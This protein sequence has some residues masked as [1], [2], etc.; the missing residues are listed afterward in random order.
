[1]ERIL[2]ER[3]KVLKA[4]VKD[5]IKKIKT[6]LL[7][8]QL[9][10][11]YK[12]SDEFLNEFVLKFRNDKRIVKNTI[13][14]IIEN[15]D[16][17]IDYLIEKEKL[18][19]NVFGISLNLLNLALEENGQKIYSNSKDFIE[20]IE[21]ILETEKINEEFS[22]KN[23]FEIVSKKGIDIYFFKNKTGRYNKAKNPSEFENY[24][25]NFLIEKITD[26]E[27]RR[28]KSDFLEVIRYFSKMVSDYYTYSLGT[29][30]GLNPTP[31]GL[32][33]LEEKETLKYK[34]NLFLNDFENEK[35]NNFFGIKEVFLKLV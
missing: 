28:L 26:K 33:E 11:E 4:M 17:M 31:Y 7:N 12:I 3:K 35:T 23:F 6:P 24:C 19:N 18:Q 27:T 14:E 29:F 30:G 21:K 34:I 5:F 32:F 1:M 20:K 8:R 16:M 2:V 9:F 15:K 13:Q 10:R 25:N 22:F